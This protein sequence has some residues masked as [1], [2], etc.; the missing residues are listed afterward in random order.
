M[1]LSIIL[2]NRRGAKFE[3]YD[4]SNPI[5]KIAINKSANLE[6]FKLHL[7]NYLSSNYTRMLD[8]TNRFLESRMRSS[9]IKNKINQIKNLQMANNEIQKFNISSVYQNVYYL[10]V[11]LAEVEIS[12]PL[13]NSDEV[14]KPTAN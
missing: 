4:E 10:G 8:V 7:S 12:S 3:Y 13:F 9:S 14:I 2:K 5:L 6:E 1:D 11:Y